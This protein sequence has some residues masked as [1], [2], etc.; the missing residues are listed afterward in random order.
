[1][2]RPDG[3]R[4]DAELRVEFPAQLPLNEGDDLLSLNVR[5]KIG[6]REKNDDPWGVTKQYANKAFR[7]ADIGRVALIPVL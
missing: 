4:D 7:D 6:L 1:M 3:K 5:Y 2:R